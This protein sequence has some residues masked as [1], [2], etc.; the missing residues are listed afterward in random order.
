MNNLASIEDK[1]TQLYLG[2]LPIERSSNTMREEPKE[3]CSA[4]EQR[5]EKHMMVIA[6][7]LNRYDSKKYSI[8]TQPEAVVSVVRS[9]STEHC[10]LFLLSSLEG[11]DI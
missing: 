9:C 2:E 6:A 1:I 10:L 3:L 11:R 5:D 4:Y 7:A 8:S